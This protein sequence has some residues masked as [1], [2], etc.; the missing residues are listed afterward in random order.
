[1]SGAIEDRPFARLAARS[2]RATNA[3]RLLSSS[4]TPCPAGTYSTEAGAT[5][6][7]CIVNPNALP[8]LAWSKVPPPTSLVAGITGKGYAAGFSSGSSAALILGGETGQGVSAPLPPRL[9]FSGGSL[10]QLAIVIEASQSTER[11]VPDYIEVDHHK[12]TAKFN[13]IPGLHD[14]PYPVQMEPNLVVEF[15]SR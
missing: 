5:Q 4:G 10:Q 13:R 9:A 6:N 1:M 11:D 15:Y 14:V 8:A 3:R 7:N 2:D 12:F